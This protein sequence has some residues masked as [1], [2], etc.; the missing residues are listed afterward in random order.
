MGEIRNSWDYQIILPLVQSYLKDRAW[1]KSASSTA[2]QDY[3]E[4]L[5]EIDGRR[6]VRIE[7]DIAHA[8]NDCGYRRVSNTG[9]GFVRTSLGIQL[10]PD[11]A[12]F[13]ELRE[14]SV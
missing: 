12:S 11:P 7:W 13:R 10:I 9:K 8:L 4:A 6:I 3:I 5:P 14:I 1:P 2:I